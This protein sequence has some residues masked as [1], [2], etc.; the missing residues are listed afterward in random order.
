MP[1]TLIGLIETPVSSALVLILRSGLMPLMNSISLAV[2]GLPASNSTPAYR[3]SVFSRTMTRSIGVS[4]K[5]VRTPGYCLQGR[6]QANRPRA[7]RR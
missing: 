7:C 4:E 5:K 6:M 1:E 2:S 3:S